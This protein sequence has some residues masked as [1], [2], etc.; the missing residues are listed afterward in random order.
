M[1]TLEFLEPKTLKEAC[2]L[3]SKYKEEA[4]L[5]AGGQ[6]L[7]PI[8]QQRLIAP[9]YLINIKDLPGLEYI[10]ETDDGLKIGALTTESAIETSYTI[11]QKFPIL[12]EAAHSIASVQIRNW[13]TVGGSISQ[14]DPT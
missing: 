9:K 8:L 2:L 5:I 12:A 7:V 4:R 10:K 1:R 14:S 3:S 6:S 13:G 11:K